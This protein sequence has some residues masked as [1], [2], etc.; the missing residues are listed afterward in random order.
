MRGV[1]GVFFIFSVCVCFVPGSM[2]VSV[3]IAIVHL[4]Q[5][6]STHTAPTPVPMGSVHA[7]IITKPSRAGLAV[8]R[9]ELVEPG[10]AAGVFRGM[11]GPCVK[12]LERTYQVRAKY[13]IPFFLFCKKFCRARPQPT[14][15]STGR[16]TV[17]L[18]HAAVT[19]LLSGRST[20]GGTGRVC[21]R[22]RSCGT[23]YE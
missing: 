4:G 16:P 23:W 13:I 21:G 3:N 17:S 20:D 6:R 12:S 10:A 11:A 14:T 22:C 1:Y 9:S 15:P 2:F 18:R 7:Q 19:L 8:S 5:T